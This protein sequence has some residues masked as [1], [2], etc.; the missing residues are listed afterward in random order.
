LTL[1]DSIIAQP[2]VA[3]LDYTGNAGDLDIKYVMSNNISTLPGGADVVVG[4]PTFVDAANGDYH[5]AKNSYGLDFAPAITG[6]DRDLDGLPHDQDLPTVPNVYGVRDLGAYERQNLFNEC[7]T[8]DSL[9]CDGF[10]P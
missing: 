10:E 4:V 6:D 3:T 7:G 8:S 9:F 1:H 5:L 2:G